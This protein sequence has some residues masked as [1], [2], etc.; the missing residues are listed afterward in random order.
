VRAP[1]SGIIPSTSARF[2]T[3]RAAEGNRPMQRQPP[4]VL[5][6]FCSTSS[7]TST[8]ARAGCA[9]SSRRRPSGLYI[10]WVPVR[11]CAGC[12]SRPTRLLFTGASA[13][14]PSPRAASRRDLAQA[15]AAQAHE[16]SHPCQRRAH[17]QRRRERH[18]RL[19]L[20]RVQGVFIRHTHTHTQAT[21]LG[22]L[23]QEQ[24]AIGDFDFYECEALHGTHST[25]IAHT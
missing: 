24:R 14:L 5:P 20:L 7:Q 18:R 11:A 12:I 10:T 3:D 17:R 13:R 6:F 8:Y 21:A 22:H 19:R 25:Y 9:Q 15:A 16:A 2:E 1:P 23:P 4:P